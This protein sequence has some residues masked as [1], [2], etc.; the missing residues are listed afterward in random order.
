M[1]SYAARMQYTR[2]VI[3]RVRRIGTLECESEVEWEGERER[4]PVIL[5]YKCD[6]LSSVY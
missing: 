4:L 1:L 3:S 6:K 5:T 2:W